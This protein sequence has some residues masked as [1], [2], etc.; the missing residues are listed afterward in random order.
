MTFPT[1]ST[2]ARARKPRQRS[3]KKLSARTAATLS[4]PGRHSDGGGLYLE[5]SSRAGASRRSW[6]YLF[7]W[8][9]KPKSMGLG[10]F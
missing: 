10:A 2:I 7:T 3:E 5:I 8:Y 6:L 4:K 9:G 1:D